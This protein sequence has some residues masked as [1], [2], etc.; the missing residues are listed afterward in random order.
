ALEDE[1]DAAPKAAP[2]FAHDAFSNS[3]HLQF[4]LKGGLAAMACYM[5]YTSVD[6]PG[7]STSV[8]TCVF[9]ALTTIGAS[10]QK[11]VLRIGG[12]IVGGFVFGL[13]AQIFILPSVDTIFGFTIL[14][15]IV[16]AISA[17]IMTASPR[18]S[19]LGVQVA[20]AYY[21]IHLQAFKFET[22]LA[23]GR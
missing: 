4:G 18:I 2:L 3:A 22:S 19:Y 23:T 20:L 13:G 15:V 21:L 11:Q 6:W 7:I 8:V 1:Q 9:T 14:F 16:T 12:A 5:V 17:W 10:R